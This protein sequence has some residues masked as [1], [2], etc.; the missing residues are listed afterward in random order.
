MKTSLR[1]FFAAA[2]LMVALTATAQP[3][4]TGSNVNPVIGTSF[5][6]NTCNYVSEGNS[7]A[8]QTWDLSSMNVTDS[9]KV[10][11]ELPSNTQYSN[12]F[13]SANIAWVRS[14]SDEVA[15]YNA[16]S[17]ALQFYGMHIPGTTTL[18][19]DDP[20]DELQFPITYDDS[21]T[22]TWDVEYTANGIT[23]YREGTTTVTADGYGTLITPEGTFNN[24]LRVHTE[25]IYQD[26]AS[27][28]GSPYIMDYDLNAYT[29]YK[30]GYHSFLATTFS[31]NSP[32]GPQS[33]ASYIS[34]L[35]VSTNEITRDI[36]CKVFP[37]P[38]SENVNIELSAKG[39]VSV[40]LLNSAGQQVEA[41]VH[42]QDQNLRIDVSNL[43]EGLYLVRI[44]QD[45]TNLIT[46]KIV[47]NR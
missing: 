19:Y 15:Y 1:L 43:P 29:W 17:S 41:T 2:S 42:E 5:T 3:T 44:V 36:S 4:L 9:T 14:G 32:N 12:S 24:V 33:S 22:D 6:S 47:V 37:N 23:F 35:P 26:S 30:E 10:S 18:S 39:D 34:N 16:S 31:L 28:S 21:Y 40:K 38:A 7:G 25:Q 13:P 45:E 46:K 8:D 27:I 11:I 20:E